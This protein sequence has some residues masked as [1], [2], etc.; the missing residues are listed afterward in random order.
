VEQLA[1][2]RAFFPNLSVPIRDM[3]GAQRQCVA[4]AWAAAFAVTLVI[5]QEPT[6]VLGV[7]ETVQ[8]KNTIRGLKERGVP[9]I[10]IFRG[11]RQVFDL[12]DRIVVIRRSMAWHGMALMRRDNTGGND[13]V[14]Y[15]TG[16]E[17]WRRR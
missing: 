2:L 12:V 1:S 16:G 3:P 9:L 4:V 10:L 13:S 17:G 15:I 14:S 5:A 6:A 8:G 7:P 11:L